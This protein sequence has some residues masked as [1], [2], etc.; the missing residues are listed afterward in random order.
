MP[1][2]ALDVNLAISHVDVTIS[3]RYEVL[4][5]VMARYFGIMEGLNTFLKELCHPYRNWQFILK[6]GRGYALDYF[7]LLKTH[8][9]GPDAAKLYIDI[10]LE[11]LDSSQNSD[12][13]TDAVDNLLLYLQKII[14]DSGEELSRFLTSLDYGFNRIRSY[15]DETFLLFVKSY[16]QINRLAKD[17]LEKTPP[18]KKCKINRPDNYFIK[19]YSMDPIKNE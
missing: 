13:K 4:Q 12:L 8:P 14:K 1:S 19:L 3:D 7:H 9:K 6:E 11:A 16:Y 15:D 10:F 5:E 17:L 2:K 18:V